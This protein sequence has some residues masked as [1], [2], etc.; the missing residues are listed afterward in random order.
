M[1][2]D[3]RMDDLNR[4]VETLTQEI[5]DREGF[6]RHIQQAR[7][8]V[9]DDDLIE[10]ANTLI[11]TAERRNDRDRKQRDALYAQLNLLDNI[12]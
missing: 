2:I 3:E 7:H 12:A 11:Q 4:K 1:S 5:S 9:P 8:R 10:L 6:I